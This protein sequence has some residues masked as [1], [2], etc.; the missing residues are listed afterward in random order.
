M[1]LAKYLPFFQLHVQD[2]NCNLFWTHD[3]FFFIFKLA[4]TFIAFSLLFELHFLPPNFH[5][6]LTYALLTF[7]NNL[8]L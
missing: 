6:H 3:V 7:L 5:L 2:F 1:I 4:P 8:F